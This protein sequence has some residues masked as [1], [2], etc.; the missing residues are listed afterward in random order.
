MAGTAPG[1]VVAEFDLAA[2]REAR[3]EDSFRLRAS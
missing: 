3:I 2:I 1:L